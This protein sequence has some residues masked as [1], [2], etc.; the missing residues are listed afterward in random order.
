MPTTT[1]AGKFIIL[2][3]EEYP[4]DLEKNK[5]IPVPSMEIST[6]HIEEVAM[7]LWEDSPINSSIGT[8]N[9]PPPIPKKVAT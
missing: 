8:I 9:I 1:K 4:T 3:Y 2:E 5:Y 6:M 7:D